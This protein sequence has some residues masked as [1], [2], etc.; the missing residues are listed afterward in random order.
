MKKQKMVSLTDETAKI[1]SR[2]DNFSQWVRIGLRNVQQGDDVAT[3]TIRRIRFA[4]ACYMMASVLQ[5]NGE[6]PNADL[7]DIVAF[8][9]G[10]ISMEEY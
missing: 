10:E 3:E 5:E 2:M 6:H 7:D 4:K 1:A 8:Y 9:L